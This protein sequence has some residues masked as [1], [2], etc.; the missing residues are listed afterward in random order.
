[1]ARRRRRRMTRKQ[2]R[3]RKRRMQAAGL[4]FAGCIVVLGIFCGVLHHYVSKFPKDKI[5]KNVYVGNVDLSGLSKAEARE[6]L[7]AQKEA[8]EKQTVSLAVEGQSVEATLEEYGLDYKDIQKNVNKA[9]DYGKSGGLFIRYKSL[10]KLAKE[11]M[12]IGPE[13]TLDKKASEGILEEQAVPLARHAQ[14][15]TITKNGKEL[16]INKEEIGETVDKAGTI[17]AIKKHLNDAWNHE[18]FALDAKVKE[19]KPTVT[20]ADLSTIQD[21]LGSFSTDAGGGERWKNLKNGVEKLNGTVV[22][23]GEQVSVHDVTAPYDEEHGYVQAGSYENGQVVDTYGGGICQVSTTLY[24]AVLFSE[25]KVIKRYPHSMLVAYVPPSRDAAIAGDTKDFVFENNYDTPIYIYGEIDDDN[26]L[27]FTIYGKETRDKTRKIEFES[28]V[29]STEEP[30]VKYKAD[31][32][33]ALGDMEVTGS[34]HTGKEVK[35][36]KIVYENGKQI[37]KDAINESTYSKADKTISVGVKTKNS[38]ASEIVREAI[39]TQDS[40]KIQAAI[41]KAGSMDSSSGE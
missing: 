3:L 29:V 31:A 17:K 4:V 23:P 20:A 8:D 28:E 1:M 40:E 16:K 10:R 2:A 15:A 14:N 9:M 12:V 13:Y 27:C 24:N 37:S 35:L 32:E 7:T 33:R 30:G 34:A 22:M 25:L 39:A 38:S 5:A 11:K 36:W 41:S 26:Q 6:K 19:E 18:S 21:E